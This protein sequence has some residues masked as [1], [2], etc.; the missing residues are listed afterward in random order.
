MS[1]VAEQLRMIEHAAPLELRGTVSELRGLTLRV[2]DLPIPVGAMAKIIT[3]S[4][5]GFGVLGEVVGYEQ[6]EAIIIPLT[7]ID[8]V[9]PG[10]QVIGMHQT[11]QVRVGDSLLGRVVNGLGQPID[12]A[13]P[14]RQ[15]VSRPLRPQ[16]V[17]PLARPLIDEPL[18][19][20]V[21]SIDCLNTL[22]RGQRI[23]VFAA[24]GMGK[25]TLLGM[26]AKQ[27]D[28]D[29]NVIAL[30]GERGREVRDFVEQNLGEEGLKRSVVVCATGDESPLLRI[31]AAY[32]ATTIAEYF[33]D[34]GK[35][36]LLIMDSVTR[37]CQ[38]QRQIGLAAGEP[39]A[40]KGYPPSVFSLLPQLLE[41]SGR[42]EQGSITGIY[43]VL[44]EGDDINEPISDA[45]R[46]I[47]DGHIQ[48]SRKLAERAHFP[49]VDVLQSISRV[50]PDVADQEHQLARQQII[51][52]VAAYREVEDL[53]TIG[54]YSPGSNPDYDLAIAIKPTIDQ[55]LQ[56]GRATPANATA[57]YAS[58]RSQVMALIQRMAQAQQ[59]VE[60]T[61]GNNRNPNAAQRPA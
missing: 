14:L 36:V 10:D 54:A 39:P 56:Q 45:C 13:G 38:A 21:R 2:V 4:A 12:N 1:I 15:T 9:R 35:D 24:A 46:G 41:R 50:M 20:G 30:V 44:V 25:S 58:A 32:A 59:E 22:G 43:S 17:D 28:A 60:K 6:D 5:G 31:R 8:G 40:T 57:N 47:L 53:L 19:T 49:A 33:R 51:R 34:A 61:L 55:L 11:Q 37:F 26:M 18:A 48:L 42:T 27:T 16:P 23:G 52:M 7:G 3:Q 29:V